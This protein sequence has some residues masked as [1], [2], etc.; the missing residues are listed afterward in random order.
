MANV[1][2][3][4]HRGSCPAT[5]RLNGGAVVEAATAAADSEAGVR[6]SGTAH[7]HLKAV[8]HSSGC[9]FLVDDGSSAGGR[10]CVYTA[11]GFCIAP[12]GLSHDTGCDLLSGWQPGSHGVFRHSAAGTPIRASSWV[13]AD[14]F[15]QF[16]RVFSHHAS[17]CS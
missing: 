10:C 7:E 2:M 15:D 13:E 11:S 16:V 1:L 5:P 9:N 14:D 12:G 8:H 4:K 17:I 3:S 6:A